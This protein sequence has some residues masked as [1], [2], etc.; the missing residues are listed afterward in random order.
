MILP[1][2]ALCS[3][4]EMAAAEIVP[5]RISRELPASIPLLKKYL[6]KG[7]RHRC[8]AGARGHIQS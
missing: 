1:T 7:K 2:K 6:T 5:H 4:H 3:S 8:L